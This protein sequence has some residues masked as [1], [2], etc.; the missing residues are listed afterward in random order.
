MKIQY[1]SKKHFHKV[2]NLFIFILLLNVVML[3]HY[4]AVSHEIATLSQ[5]GYQVLC[6]AVVLC[7]Q[8]AIWLGRATGG[9][10]SPPTRTETEPAHT[11]C[12]AN[13]LE[14]WRR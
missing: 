12:P 3:S 2:F 5:V 1:N 7:L 8:A 14:V 11:F 10:L 13:Q 4:A 6:G 9:G